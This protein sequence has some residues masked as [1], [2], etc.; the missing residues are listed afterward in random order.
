[1]HHIREKNNLWSRAVTERPCPGSA[2]GFNPSRRPPLLPSHTTSPA[3]P[4]ASVE[5]LP[6]PSVILAHRS[7]SRQQNPCIWDNAHQL[8]TASAI[9]FTHLER[10]FLS[11][12]SEPGPLHSCFFLIKAML[13]L[14]ELFLSFSRKLK[15]FFSG[16]LMIDR[17]HWKALEIRHLVRINWQQ[18]VTSDVSGWSENFLY[19]PR[20]V[21]YTKLNV[22]PSNWWRLHLQVLL[23]SGSTESKRTSQ[24]PKDGVV[25]R[26]LAWYLGNWDDVLVLSPRKLWNPPR[27]ED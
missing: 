12:R 1:M 27:P 11:I 19:F 14:P 4:T 15:S 20:A 25:V 7:K 22:G 6:N 8:I 23:S 26:A 9:V 13:A 10:L 21:T 17:C 3:L 5:V 18:F 24:M 2:A 16:C